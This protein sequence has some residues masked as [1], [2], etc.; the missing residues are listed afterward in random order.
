MLENRTLRLV[1]GGVTLVGV[2]YLTYK[3]WK[4]YVRKADQKKH[5][6]SE[7]YQEEPRLIT[8]ASNYS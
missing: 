7:I 2:S 1:L 6:E 4:N 3:F 5:K 8:I